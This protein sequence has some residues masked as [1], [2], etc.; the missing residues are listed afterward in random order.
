LCRNKFPNLILC[1]QRQYI[2]PRWSR[3][4]AEVMWGTC[5][6]APTYRSGHWLLVSDSMYLQ[7]YRSIFSDFIKVYFIV[8]KP[9][10]GVI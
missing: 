3:I 10:S 5:S 6:P 1:P 4:L 9:S 2:C 7:L 8:L